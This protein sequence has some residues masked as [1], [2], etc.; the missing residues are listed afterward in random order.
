MV[1]LT[2]ILPITYRTMLRHRTGA[3]SSQERDM[4]VTEQIDG[5]KWPQLDPQ[6]LH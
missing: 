2:V 4:H 1:L 3:S 6:Q 5:P